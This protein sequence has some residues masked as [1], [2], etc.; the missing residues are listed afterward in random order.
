MGVG[1]VDLCMDL[2]GVFA[3]YFFV[4]RRMMDR[5]DGK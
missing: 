5:G 1:E 3:I 4:G 2:V